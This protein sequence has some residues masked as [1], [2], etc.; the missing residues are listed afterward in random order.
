MW[1]NRN[2]R[3]K[4]KIYVWT[5]YQTRT[6]L[7]A[8]AS[9][10]QSRDN[11]RIR[12]FGEGFVVKQIIKLKAFLARAA[13]AADGGMPRE[14]QSKY[15]NRVKRSAFLVMLLLLP[16]PLPTTTVIC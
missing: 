6:R 2:N 10:P 7:P 16:L 4:L 12:L 3:K 5:F 14:M 1:K 11:L 9:A 13:K 8:G 15:G